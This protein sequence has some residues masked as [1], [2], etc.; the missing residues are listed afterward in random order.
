MPLK[1]IVAS[2]SSSAHRIEHGMAMHF[3]LHYLHL[4]QNTCSL[5]DKR[6][7]LHLH[8]HNW[9]LLHEEGNRT[10]NG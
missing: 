4:M 7:L 8:F 9:L 6:L 1:L 2:I 3:N 5:F 10:R